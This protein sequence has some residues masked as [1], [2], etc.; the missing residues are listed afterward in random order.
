MVVFGL[1]CIDNLVLILFICVCVSKMTDRYGGL[2]F[3]MLIFFDAEFTDFIDCELISLGLISEDGQYEL[4]LEVQDFD[5]LK[6]NAFVLAA[7]CSCLGRI[8]DAEVSKTD[9]KNRLMAWFATL[10][11][12]VTVACDSQHDRDLLADVFDGDWPINL[13]G[14]LDLRPLMDSRAFNRAVARHHTKGRPWHHAL[15][16][17][18]AHRAGWLAW[19]AENDTR[20]V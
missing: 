14:W 7:V 10:P 15:F 11:Y 12:S 4:Y 20:E 13:A 17:A 6:C 19:V 18:Q 3:I 16:D 1:A 8:A 9:L 5:R 2:A